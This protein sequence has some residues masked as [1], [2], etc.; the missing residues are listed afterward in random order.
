MVNIAVIGVGNMGYHHCRVYSELP[1]ATLVACSDVDES[2]LEIARNKFKCKTYTD[3][4]EM[5]S[6]EKLDG[7]SIVA[8]TS[9]HF[10]VALETIKNG[11]PFLV[12]KPIASTMEEAEELSQRAGEKDIPFLI[13]HIERFNPAV[14]KLKEMI[15]SG[16]LGEII[17]VHAKRVGLYPPQIQDSNIIVDVSIHDIEILNFLLDATPDDIYVNAGTVNG[18]KEDYVGILANYSGKTG[19]IQSNWITPIKI[20]KLYV[21]ATK[22]YVEV[23]YIN[24]EIRMF[25]NIAIKSFAD[26]S[27]F[28]KI[29]TPGEN[30][31]EIETQEPLKLELSHFLEVIKGKTDPLVKPQHGI[32][33]LKIA[34]ELSNEVTRKSLS[35]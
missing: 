16:E 12:E 19:I 6:S 22:A 14:L 10:E 31:V 33:A 26:F 34:L 9:R 2:K 18:S 28:Q 27:S 32:N 24:Q 35:T 11:I 23:D 29:S 20:R 17:T 25:E 13:G 8:P 5:L 3:F 21:T 15:D 7:V 4:K 30:Y 1:G